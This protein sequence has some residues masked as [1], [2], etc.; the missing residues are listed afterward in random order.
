MICFVCGDDERS[1]ESSVLWDNSVTLKRTVC[2]ACRPFWEVSLPL[3]TWRRDGRLGCSLCGA[4]PLRVNDS[5]YYR[6]RDRTLV[7]YGTEYVICQTCF[8]SKLR[9][10][11]AQTALAARRHAESAI[12]A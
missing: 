7:N 4:D 3:V 6:I 12:D 8:S 10:V 5:A 2:V 11:V 9:M 1:V